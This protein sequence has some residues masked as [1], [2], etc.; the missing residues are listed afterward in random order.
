MN[1]ASLRFKDTLI[2][3]SLKSAVFQG[4]DQ[5]LMLLFTLIIAT[6]LSKERFGELSFILFGINLL[7]TLSSSGNSY[8]F[9]RSKDVLQRNNPL[10][11]KHGMILIATLSSIFYLYFFNNNFGVLIFISVMAYSYNNYTH[12]MSAKA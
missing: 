4:I 5:T 9:L 1:T 11:V 6:Q 10:L 7:T 12:F 8:Y 2:K 3:N